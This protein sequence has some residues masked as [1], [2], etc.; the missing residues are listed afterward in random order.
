MANEQTQR[1]AQRLITD[2][3]NFRAALLAEAEACVEKASDDA[4]MICLLLERKIYWAMNAYALRALPEA[5]ALPAVVDY[6]APAAPA[7][8]GGKCRH[9][10]HGDGDGKVACSLCGAPK[11]ARGR[12]AKPPAE[13]QSVISAAA[14]NSAAQHPPAVPAAPVA[15]VAP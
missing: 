15:T 9:E 4:A 10:W 5:P 13:T 12:K 6:P 14:G 11:S 3:E 8:A 7:A 1:D 2:S